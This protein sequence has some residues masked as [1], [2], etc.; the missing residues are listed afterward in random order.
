MWDFNAER[1]YESIKDRFPFE[2]EVGIVL[3][4]GL[5]EFVTSINAIERIP[6]RDIDSFPFSTTVG[7]AGIFIFAE[8]NGIKLVIMQGRVHYYE[9]Y[10]TPEVVIPIRV[11]KLM[12]IKTLLLSNSAGGISDKLNVGD[13]MIISDHIAS[14]VPTPFRGVELSLFGGRRFHD[15]SEV[16]NSELRELLVTA[17]KEMSISYGEGVYI[18]V[19]GPQYETPAEIRAYKTWGADAVGMSTA[20]EA[21]FANALGIR[22]AGVSCITNK[23]AGLG[24]TLSHEEVTM[25]ADRNSMNLSRLV[26]RFLELYKDSLS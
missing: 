22:V 8:Y 21:A 11:M 20:I 6:Y 2:P 13:I 12:G 17:A 19:T 16:Y 25:S 26:L 9:G 3:G 5:V 15:M 4:S 10:E 18:Q 14:L 24:G 7:H 23:A 1:A